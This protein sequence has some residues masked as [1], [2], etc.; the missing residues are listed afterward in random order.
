MIKKYENLYPMT[1]W[2]GLYSDFKEA[3]KKFMF[4]SSVEGQRGREED[5][6]PRELNTHTGGVTYIVRD[7]R[8]REKGV[9]I[10]IN[11][12][13][14]ADGLLT[15]MLMDI[16]AHEA[17]HATDAVY[18]VIGESCRTYDEGNEPHAYLLGWFVGRITEYIIQI[19]HE[20]RKRKKV[21]RR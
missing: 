16:I 8:R 19:V 10:L 12:E 21:R 3:I 13:F 14:F 2:V 11:E 7:K 9:L 6:T 4:Y 1:F 5:V 20:R 17:S 18:Q 15:S